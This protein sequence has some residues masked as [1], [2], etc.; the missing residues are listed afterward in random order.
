ML[1]KSPISEAGA[2]RAASRDPYRLRDAVAAA[3]GAGWDLTKPRTLTAA[4]DRLA[5]LYGPPDAP[6]WP[7]R[8]A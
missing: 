3:E 4:R 8:P 6:E 7:R 2:R 1:V 5:G